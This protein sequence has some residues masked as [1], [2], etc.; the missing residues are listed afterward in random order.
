MGSGNKDRGQAS[1][2]GE[3]VG[4]ISGGGGQRGEEGG[5]ACGLDGV[6]HPQLGVFQVGGLAV[7]VD[8]YKDVVHTC[9][10]NRRGGW[11]G[12]SAQVPLLCA[13][14]PV[15]GSNLGQA[16]PTK[17]LGLTQSPGPTHQISWLHPASPSPTH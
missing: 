14:G 15:T 11:V 4:R 6:D 8:E 7:C 16:P 3:D 17:L 10:K 12:S 1:H 5:F 2:L 9:R 13:S